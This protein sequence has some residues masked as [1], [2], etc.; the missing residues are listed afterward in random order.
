MF[1]DRPGDEEQR[2]KEAVESEYVCPLC[3]HNRSFHIFIKEMQS[4]FCKVRNCHCRR[5]VPR[6]MHYATDL[7]EQWR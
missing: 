6:M 4:Y 2:A 3:N 5:H 7:L 1:V